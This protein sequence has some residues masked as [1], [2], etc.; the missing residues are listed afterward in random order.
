MFPP[1]VIAQN[2]FLQ[3]NNIWKEERKPYKTLPADNIDHILQKRPFF[4]SA[5]EKRNDMTRINLFSF[6]IDCA[7]SKK[8]SIPRK[9]D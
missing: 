1:G 4:S 8:K 6:Y 2:Y 9:Q 5:F 7:R 3:R